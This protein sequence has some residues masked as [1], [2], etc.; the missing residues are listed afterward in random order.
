M[1]EGFLEVPGGKIWYGLCNE[2]VNSELE[3]KI[4]L[5]CIHGGPGYTHNSFTPLANLERKVVFYDQLGCGK[6][7]RPNDQSLWTIERHVSELDCLIKH[8]G[9]TK[10]YLLCL[11]YTSPSPRD[12]RGSRMPSSA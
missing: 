10:V 7:D 12:Q 6:S 11:L 4:P 5:I 8:L 1:T 3:E 9:F 2:S